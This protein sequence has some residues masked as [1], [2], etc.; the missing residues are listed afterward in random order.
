MAYHTSG[1]EQARETF[2][3]Q[4]LTDA[5]LRLIF[6]G[7]YTALSSAG[8]SYLPSWAGE[9]P[10]HFNIN[11]FLDLPTMLELTQHLMHEARVQ[12]FNN[13]RQLCAAIILCAHPE[14]KVVRV[15]NTDYFIV[16]PEA[17]QEFLNSKYFKGYSVNCKV[18]VL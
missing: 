13:P 17:L 16:E 11:S 12:G 1:V 6:A 4:R 15:E 7:C 3:F 18:E 14:Y 5:E 8:N 9:V 10:A 2:D